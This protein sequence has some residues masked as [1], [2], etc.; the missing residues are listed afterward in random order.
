METIDETLL[1]EFRES[2]CEICSRRPPS[3]PHHIESRGMGGGNR[4]D[5][6]SNLVALCAKHHR[7]VHDGNIKRDVLKAIVSF[8][9]DS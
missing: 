6:R 5:I 2:A 9:G 3:E 7:E 8:R 1:D 4:K